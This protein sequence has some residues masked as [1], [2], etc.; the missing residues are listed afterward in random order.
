MQT[1]KI[2]KN[3][4]NDYLEWSNNDW[5]TFSR[6]LQTNQTLCKTYSQQCLAFQKTISTSWLKHLQNT[7]KSPFQTP[8]VLAFELKVASKPFSKKL[9]ITNLDLNSLPHF[10]SLSQKMVSASS[11]KNLQKTKKCYFQM[12]TIL[13]LMLKE[14]S[15]LWPDFDLNCFWCFFVSLFFRK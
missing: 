13:V 10:A 2:F 1:F 15:K 11:I 14:A 7:E 9:P 6:K 12:P 5:K 3:S 4:S 8:T